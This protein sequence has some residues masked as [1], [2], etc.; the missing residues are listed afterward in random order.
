MKK[1]VNEIYY[2]LGKDT[3]KLP[4]LLLMFLGVSLLDIIG[5]GLITPYIAT[6]VNPNIADTGF[7]KILNSFFDMPLNS[8]LT[9]YLASGILFLIFLLKSIVIIIINYRI[10]KFS[11]GQQVRLRSLLMRTYQNLPYLTYLKRSSSE[12][13]YNIYNLV[14]QFSSAV[15]LSGLRT[16]SDI[17]VALM[18]FAFLAWSNIY[19]FALLVFILSVSLFLYDKSFRKR[20][21]RSGQIT[22]AA[23]TKL[24]QSIHEG[25]DGLKEIRLLG[26]ED[27]FRQ[28]VDVAAGKIRDN[29]IIYRLILTSP[30]YILELILVGF[31]V[32]LIIGNSFF[33]GDRLGLTSTLIV[34]GVA[35]IRLMP[36]FNSLSST[37]N[38]F[39]FNRDTV[40]KLYSD[41]FNLTTHKDH[42]NQSVMS[43]NNVIQEEFSSL[44][45]NKVSFSY[46]KSNKKIL[47]NVSIE[48]NKNEVIGVVGASGSGK[49]T[50][51]NII[52]GL[53]PVTKGSVEYNNTNI[54]ECKPYFQSQIAYL[55][56]DVYIINDSIKNNVALGLHETKID[57]K[58]LNDAIRKAQLSD[59]V[60]NSPMGVETVLGF[61]GVKISGGQRQRIALARTFYHQRNIIFMDESTSALDNET[62]H[63]ISEEIK[64]LKGEK[65]VIIISHR[66]SILKY[67]DR[68]YQMDRKGGVVATDYNTIVF[69]GEQKK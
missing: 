24:S 57:N 38:Q 41:L 10:T 16:I 64:K 28:K 11:Q 62:E 42:L 48:I 1:Y 32:L 39:R 14:G 22:N 35:A 65:T 55:P 66:L 47:S 59:F 51:V 69:Q 34:Y 18:V 49:S 3:K 4:L 33:E 56:Q 61:N 26:V 12:Y 67:C 20:L 50:L 19:A 30:R 2:L 9:L 25:I 60:N 8:E 23:S 43:T 5:L 31:I 13:V 52:L 45:V 21:S 68:I 46:P 54:Q 7:Y 37:I 63:E 27:F 44:K 36:I 29:Q 17:I 6:V 40:S 58:R 53:L 15:V